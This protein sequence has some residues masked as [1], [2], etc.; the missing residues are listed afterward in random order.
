MYTNMNLLN[1]IAPSYSSTIVVVIVVVNNS[2]VKSNILV[3]C[4]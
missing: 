4:S 3:S 1:G 2:L